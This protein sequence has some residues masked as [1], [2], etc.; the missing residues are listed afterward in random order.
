MPKSAALPVRLPVNE[1][2]VRP[3]MA[4]VAQE[5]SNPNGESLCTI[6]PAQNRSTIMMAEV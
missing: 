4:S 3:K 1:S 5:A 2:A 6:G